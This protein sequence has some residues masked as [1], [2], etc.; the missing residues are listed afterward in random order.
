MARSRRE[1]R[2]RPGLLDDYPDIVR[3]G[4][5][6]E[7]W[8]LIRSLIERCIEDDVLPKERAVQAGSNHVAANRC[9]VAACQPSEVA[10]APTVRSGVSGNEVLDHLQ[11]LGS[12]FST[13]G[14][15]RFEVVCLLV[16]EVDHP[17]NVAFQFD[18]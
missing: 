9:L 11:S 15:L 6:E 5:W 17:T 1:E 10:F 12:R 13:R 18:S 4:I 14:M 16:V 7:L 2:G 3:V 8:Q